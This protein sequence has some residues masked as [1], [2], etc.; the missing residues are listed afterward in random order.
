M[1]KNYTKVIAQGSYGYNFN[2]Q[3]I[4]MRLME[5]RHRHRVVFVHEQRSGFD[6]RCQLPAV[7]AFSLVQGGILRGLW[8]NSQA[9]CVLLCTI[10]ILNMF[11][12]M[13]TIYALKIGAVEVN[14]IMCILFETNPISAGF[15]KITMVLAMTLLMWRCRYFRVALQAAI[16]SFI[17]YFAIFCYHIAGAIVFSL[18]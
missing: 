6:R 9:L 10:N 18:W 17:V 11:D 2:C 5:R 8:V 15:V 14:P 4:D 7:E 13:L 3:S 16:L 12:L 1:K